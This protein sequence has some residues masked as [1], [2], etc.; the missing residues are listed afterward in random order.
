M[1]IP[2]T[3]GQ[4]CKMQWSLGFR[5]VSVSGTHRHYLV[6]A[7]PTHPVVVNSTGVT[8]RPP[9]PQNVDVVVPGREGPVFCDAHRARYEASKQVNR[10]GRGVWDARVLVGPS[11]RD[12]SRH[13]AVR[14]EAMCA[15]P[16][17]VMSNT[18][19]YMAFTKSDAKHQI[20]AAYF[21]DPMSLLSVV[22]SIWLNLEAAARGS[23][24]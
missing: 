11:A 24:A 17:V 21:S 16:Y 22:G 2:C 20:F 15:G 19:G 18:H 6:A 3:P 13:G 12:A 23:K 10:A 1:S 5:L 14:E 4:L 7:T 8:I 9:E